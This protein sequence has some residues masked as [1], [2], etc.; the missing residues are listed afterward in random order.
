M[1]INEIIDG[2]INKIK[3]ISDKDYKLRTLK[4]FDSLKDYIIYKLNRLLEK[5]PNKKTNLFYKELIGLYIPW[6]DIVRAKR[7]IIFINKKIKELYEKYRNKVKI[8]KDNEEIRKNSREFFGRVFSLIRRNK[9]YFCIIEELEKVYKKL[10]KIKN[11]PTVVITGLPNVGKST[12][13]KKLTDS[14]PEI[15]VYPFTTKDIKIGYI[16]TPYVDIQILD[17]PGI[18]DRDISEMNNI[19]RR[20][21]LA[22]KY[23]ANLIIFV[24]D[25]TETCGY[26]I[27]EQE[28]VLNRIKKYFD[29]DIFLYFSKS[30]LFSNKEKEIFKKI[31]DE[32]K[33]Q[34]FTDSMILKEEIINFIK[35]KK[36]FF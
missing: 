17:V 32:Y 2:S 24:L 18:L 3:K 23:L 21:V 10:P 13:L 11:L 35:E 31:V 25:L 12:L 1:I 7:R 9:K 33:L 27:K 30:D 34:F 22:L 14:E 19:E 36:L 16:R 8:L 28:N 29:V 26:S 5:F 4:R 6:K 20:A 15:D